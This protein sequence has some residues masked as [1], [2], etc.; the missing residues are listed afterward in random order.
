MP[1][2]NGEKYLPLTLD[3]V[4][5]QTIGIENLEIIIADDCSTDNTAKIIQEYKERINSDTGKETIKSISLEENKGGAFGPRNLAL[6]YVNGE[7]LMFIDSDDTYPKDACEILL[8][9]IEEYGCDIAFGRYLRHYPEENFIRKSY[10]PY[11]DTLDEPYLSYLDDLVKGSNFKGIVG[12]LWKNIFSKFFYGSS[13]DM[14]KF[15]SKESDNSHPKELDKNYKN[16]KEIFIRNIKDENKEEIA[17]LKILPSFWTKI[18]RSELISKN[19][20]NFPECVSAEDLNFLLEAYFKS[21]NGIL[22]LN[23]KIVYNY[24]MRLEVVD[25]SVTK[26]INFR[27]VYDSIKA[28]RLS[29]ELCDNFNIKNKDLFLNPYLL[30]WISLWLSRKNTKEENKIFLEEFDKLDKTKKYGLKY[31]LILKTT[32]LLLKIKS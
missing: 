10:T 14:N 32:K 21:E 6:N 26:N 2:Y 30:N 9:K 15:N 7:Y 4:I 24:F 23:D 31:K 27:L 5:N 29:S 25:K 22:F 11:I 3:S 1:V 16:N 13:I 20:I 18:Y 19:N 8:N 12:S 28:Y 17:I